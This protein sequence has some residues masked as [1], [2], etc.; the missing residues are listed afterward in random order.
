MLFY[1]G[2][3]IKLSFLWKFNKKNLA[4]T[5]KLKTKKYIFMK[6]FFNSNTPKIFHEF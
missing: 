6:I 3:K 2:F 4:I 5:V 1:M